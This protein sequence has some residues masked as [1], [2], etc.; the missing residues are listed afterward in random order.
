MTF[1][2]PVPHSKVLKNDAQALGT[3]GGRMK[4]GAKRSLGVLMVMY[5][6]ALAFAMGVLKV[7]LFPTLAIFAL[8]ATTVFCMIVGVSW[9]MEV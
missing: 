3:K 7:G 9:L 8:V 1:E 5:P 6:F 2:T 4:R